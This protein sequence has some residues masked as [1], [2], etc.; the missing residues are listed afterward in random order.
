VGESNPTGSAN[1]QLRRTARLGDDRAIGL[2]AHRVTP[3]LAESVLREVARERNL[4]LG[5]MTDG[6]DP[7]IQRM[8]DN[9]PVAVDGVRAAELGL[10]TPPPLKLIVEQY[11][12]DFCSG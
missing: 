9:W 3:R 6:F 5:P 8:V 4:T 7:R 10:P 1:W 12:E 11:L 2:P